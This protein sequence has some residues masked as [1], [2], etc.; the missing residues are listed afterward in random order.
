MNV[1]QDQG[2]FRA[3]RSTPVAPPVVALGPEWLPDEELRRLRLH[4]LRRAREVRRTH[5]PMFGPLLRI[6]TEYGAFDRAR[7]NSR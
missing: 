6:A 7:R 4:F 1:H 3:S 2:R 5:P